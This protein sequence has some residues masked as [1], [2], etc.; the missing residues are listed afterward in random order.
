[1]TVLVCYAQMNPGLL[2]AAAISALGGFQSKAGTF[3]GGGMFGFGL[4]GGHSITNL[5]KLEN[6]TID[7]AIFIPPAS[8]AIKKILGVLTVNGQMVICSSERR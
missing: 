7:S 6:N 3:V 4:G 1:M 2:D 5:G 8:T